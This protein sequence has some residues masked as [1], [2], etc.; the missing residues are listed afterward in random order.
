MQKVH[1]SS[2]DNRWG[3]AS[4]D[5]TAYITSRSTNALGLKKLITWLDSIRKI[6][7]FT[8][9]FV[10]FRQKTRN[11]LELIIMLLVEILTVWL[12]HFHPQ[13]V[14]LMLCTIFLSRC[15]WKFV[16]YFI[17]SCLLSHLTSSSSR[18]STVHKCLDSLTIPFNSYFTLNIGQERVL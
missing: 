7:K 15:N 6:R 11:A 9:T 18:L 4:H 16:A 12:S 10:Y 8:L 17:M 1:V 3:T 14:M 2:N 13:F 5:M